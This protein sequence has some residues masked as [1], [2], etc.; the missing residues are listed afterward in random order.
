[1]R[2]RHHMVY[3]AALVAQVSG[4]SDLAVHAFTLAATGDAS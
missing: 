1:M 4:R 2:D 3:A